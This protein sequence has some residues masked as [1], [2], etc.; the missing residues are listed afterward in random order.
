MED[1]YVHQYTKGEP[2]WCTVGAVISTDAHTHSPLTQTL[3]SLLF[4]IKIYILYT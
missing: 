4:T 3:F 1:M 2:R